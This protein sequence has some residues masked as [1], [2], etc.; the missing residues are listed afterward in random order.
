MKK[1]YGKVEAHIVV[2]C[3]DA[4]QDDPIYRREINRLK[5]EY[6]KKGVHVAIIEFSTPGT[7]ITPDEGMEVVEAVKRSFFKYGKNTKVYVDLITHG[8]IKKTKGF[9]EERFPIYRLKF[10]DECSKSS[11]ACGMKKAADVALELEEMILKEGGVRFNGKWIKAK[12]RRDIRKLLEE[13]YGYSGSMAGGWIK[14]IQDLHIHIAR[15]GEKIIEDLENAT[16]SNEEIENA[17]LIG[18]NLR[19]AL[20][21]VNVNS[22][23]LKYSNGELIRVDR[24]KSGKTV[25]EKAHAKASKK[26]M[27]MSETE[28]IEHEKHVAARTGPQKPKM[29]IIHSPFIWNARTR[30]AKDILG[31]RPMSGDAFAICGMGV[32]DENKRFGPYQIAG[33]LYALKHLGVKK[34]IARGKTEEEDALIIRKINADP[35]A[36]LIIEKEGAVVESYHQLMRMRNTEKKKNSLVGVNAWISWNDNRKMKKQRMLA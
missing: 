25:I 32:L 8:E 9:R 30:T 13:V 12:T 16:L 17:K 6:E 14:S 18:I 26:L 15:Q 31:K 28:R 7:Y 35:L 29:L 24:R 5:K 4:R 27:K 34:I 33:L 11:F 3:S 22:Y 21:K 19:K 10:D 23:V 2:V 36:K 20:K 1:E